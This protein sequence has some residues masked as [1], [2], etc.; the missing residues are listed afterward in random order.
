MK[1]IIPEIVITGKDK[2]KQKLVKTLN[3][4]LLR[5]INDS[6]KFQKYLIIEIIFLN[7]LLKIL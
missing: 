5:F 4:N 2:N 1:R 6:I 7:E 3:L